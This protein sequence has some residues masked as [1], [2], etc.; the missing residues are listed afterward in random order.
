VT[1]FT[2]LLRTAAGA[3]ALVAAA[4][5]S[6][7][8]TLHVP[9]DH[10]TIQAAVDAASPGDTIEV[11]PGRY[12][13]NVL[14]TK[15][16]DLVG[17][18]GP[19]LTIID[20]GGI[21]DV[22]TIDDPD[23]EKDFTVRGF[24]LTAGGHGLVVNAVDPFGIDDCDFVGN[25]GFGLRVISLDFGWVV[26][27][28]RFLGNGEGGVDS[29]QGIPAT[30]APPTFRRCLFIGGDGLKTIGIMSA[31]NLGVI[32]CTLDGGDVVSSGRATVRSTIVRGGMIEA[33]LGALVNWCNIEGGV[34]GGTGNIDADPLWADPGAGDYS[35]LPGSPCIDAGDPGGAL[36]PDG[37]RQDMGAVPWA[38]WLDLGGGVPGGAGLASLA[39]LGS[40]V[41]GTTA[42]LELSGA[43][44]ST[45]IL[46]V[47]GA[48]ELG[49]PFHGGTLW[50]V[51]L[52]LLGPVPTDPAGTLALSSPMPGSLP[53]GLEFW[54][55]AW[56]PD[57]GAAG[58]LAGSNGLR[59]TT[60]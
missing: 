56:W 55:Q 40:L 12:I 42:T 2:F 4:P 10:A 35:L 58:G 39:G 5:L 50:P 41:G 3:V 17:T 29:V 8:D 45:G 53:P 34:S 1:A 20:G 48:A 47:L 31:P 9:A 23:D 43:A 28:S 24:T 22:L 21:G 38:A 49:A 46:L 15:R 33:P 32:Q 52:L 14:V 54:L 16:L 51:P 36:D 11:A 60:P 6:L 19:A 25:S 44:P 26:T 37:S 59:G 27:D 57:G 13:E 18:G 30:I 7:A